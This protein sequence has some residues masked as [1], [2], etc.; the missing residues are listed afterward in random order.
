MPRKPN[1]NASPR[2]GLSR[3]RF[4]QGTMALGATPAMVGEAQAAGS[5]LEGYASA[6]SVKAGDA[7][8]FHVRDPQG[9]IL[10]GR[11]VGI[12]VTRM[13][14]P[15]TVVHESLTL[16]RYRS[17]PS[18]ASSK[19]CQWPVSYRLYVPSKWPSGVYWATFGAGATAC[20]VPFVVK[21]ATRAATTRVIVQVPVTTPQAYNNYGGKSIYDFNSTNGQRA[22][23]VS[24]DRPLA[25]LQSTGFDGWTPPIV[26]WLALQGIAADYC[27][28]IDL[29][30]NPEVLKGYQLFI[31]AGHDEYWSA[32]MRLNF[33]AFIAAGGN[34]AILAGNTC[35]WQVRF[36]SSLGINRTMVCHKSASADPVTTPALKT[37]NWHD[38]VP[39]LPENT[40]IGLSYYKGASWTN[41]LPRPD[42]PYVLQAPNH[43]AFTGLNWGSGTRF[44]GSYVGY[45]TDA[46]DFR[47]GS[48]GR[49]YPTGLDGS[50]STLRILAQADA[51]DWDAR[52]QALGLSGERSG[53]A[54]MAVFSRGGSQGTVFNAGTTDWV[55]GLQPE[56][57]GQTPTPIST[58]TR[59]VINKLSAPWTETAEVRQFRS[60]P[61]T[62]AAGH[63][64]AIGTEPPAGMVLEGT[65]F[66]AL[67]AP[68]T[69]STPVYRF[70]AP[71]N[72]AA[73]GRRYH[74]STSPTYLPTFGW[75][76]DGIAFHAYASDAPGRRAVYQ[77]RTLD[78]DGLTVTF[79]STDINA[80]PGWIA[81]SPAF[82]VPVA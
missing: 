55:Y 57:W 82:F 6:T 78:A 23:Q 30:A 73:N 37:V 19:G 61:A 72:G 81:D 15:D 40:S 16:V 49:S 32:A 20:N 24:F 12:K 25:D 59:N 4:V 29:H 38:L 3:R 18:N 22:S 60:T 47:F 36:D 51:S 43:W 42:T 53:Y 10:L 63:V 48:D 77:F 67:A 44:A 56:L 45:E 65:A 7:I 39:A 58:I 41:A 62:G 13:G 9:S 17:V 70:Y 27:T 31:T 69:G 35:W 74:Y 54:A 1:P 50:P 33:D 5:T 64:Y 66:Y 46:A 80:A 28:S 11:F 75:I 68:T 2:F 34:A 21:A 79:F 71:V 26:R 76:A 52:A 14:S 8:D